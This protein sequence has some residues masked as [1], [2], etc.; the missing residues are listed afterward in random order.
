MKNKILFIVMLA[1]LSCS[2]IIAYA[3]FDLDLENDGKTEALTDGVVA[4]T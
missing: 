3:G 4:V 2:A 1:L